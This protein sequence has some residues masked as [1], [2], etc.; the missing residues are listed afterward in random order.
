MTYANLACI[1]DIRFLF[2]VPLG[3]PVA[4]PICAGHSSAGAFGGF[5]H[6]ARTTRES[7]D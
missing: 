6:A 2:V 7:S 3:T 4:L 5:V 1:V